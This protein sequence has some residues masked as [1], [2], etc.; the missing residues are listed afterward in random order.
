MV[1]AVLFVVSTSEALQVSF[2]L[3]MIIFTVVWVCI[4]SVQSAHNFAALKL[5]QQTGSDI[6]YS[7]I[8]S[9]TDC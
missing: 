2:H 1:G 7:F 9:R 6:H 3:A 8:V 5:A 4:F